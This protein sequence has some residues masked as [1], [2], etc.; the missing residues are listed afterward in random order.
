M[1]IVEAAES[2]DS[3]VLTIFLIVFFI[4]LL[5]SLVVLCYCCRDNLQSKRTDLK[6]K[7]DTMKA[8]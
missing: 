4:V 5:I 6:I 8:E 7:I 2:E 1:I 3:N